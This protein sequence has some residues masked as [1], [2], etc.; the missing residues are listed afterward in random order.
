VLEPFQLARQLIDISSITGQERLLGEVLERILRT[1]GLNVEREQVSG[2]RFNI[3]ATT[4]EHPLVLLCTHIDTVPPFFA[5]SEDDEYI[6]GRGAC[7]TKGI[8]AAMLCA[9]QRLIA[10]GVAQF[11]LLFVVGEETDS[12]GAKTAN[13]SLESCGSRFVIVGEPTDSTFVAATKG[14]LTCVLRFEGVAAHSAYPE[15]GSSAILKMMGALREIVEIDWG[16]HP[17]LGEATVNVGVIRGG[18]KPNIVP[19]EAEAEMIFRT[20]GSP[21]E[22]A[23]RVSEI[24]HRYGG[25]ILSSHGNEPTFMLV[26]PDAPSSV[27]AFNTDVPHL[28]NLGRPILFGPGSILDAHT[29]AEK[30]AKGEI[31]SAIETYREL[32]S[33]I[34]SGRMDSV[35]VQG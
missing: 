2:D 14:A 21:E 18:A 13:R 15:R 26:P 4:N 24:V 3:F 12:I 6:Y 20:T 35:H 31:I 1:L 33:L 16:R 29:A 17:V 10:D 32:V 9:A 34:L 30:I 5:S 11:G 27:A 7:D 25:H 28:K 19:A 23:E 22:V 8:L